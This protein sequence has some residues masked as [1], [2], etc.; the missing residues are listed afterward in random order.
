MG[1]LPKNE[2]KEKDI[3]PRMFFIWGQSMSGKTYL[4]RQFP[5]SL[6]VN[7]DGNA[8]KV[9]TPSIDVKDFETIVKVIAEFEKGGH[10]YDT[11]IIDL[12]DDVKTML[13]DYVMRK[14]GIDAL[15]DASYG[16]AFS[17]VKQTWKSMM[18]RFSQMKQNVIFISHVTEK[19]DDNDSSRTIEVPSLEQKFYNMTMGRCDLS[20]KC[21][22]LGSTYMQVVVA[23]RDTYDESDMKDELV[24]SILRNVKGAISDGEEPKAIKPLAKKTI[25]T[26]SKLKKTKVAQSVESDPQPTMEEKAEKQ[27]KKFKPL[28]KI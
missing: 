13:E 22:K 14:L 16:K 20:I 27:I 2:P 5:N 10:T 25:T 15:A 26:S 18:V 11:L 28:K 3:T 9:N 1:L 4:A 17:E 6:I 19:S 7:T 8:K 12:V 24:K 21:R 23:K